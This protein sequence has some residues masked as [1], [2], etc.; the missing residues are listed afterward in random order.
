MAVCTL[1]GT[2][3]L[4]NASCSA[5]VVG[6]R[7]VHFPARAA[8]PEVASADDDRH[9]HA[10]ISELLDVFRDVRQH[11]VVQACVVF[12]REGLSA[13]LQD[14]PSIFRFSLG[15]HKNSLVQLDF[16]L[17]KSIT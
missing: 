10:Q 3:F 5:H 7:A 16:T 6:L 4:S 17:T 13:D 8:S 1:V 14:D 2:P 12:A 15:F 11:G 9:L